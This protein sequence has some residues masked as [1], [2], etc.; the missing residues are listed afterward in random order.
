MRICRICVLPE[1][2]PGVTLDDTGV[3]NYCRQ[4]EARRPRLE[5]QRTTMQQRFEDLVREHRGHQTYDCLAAW[6]GGKD[7]TY[8]LWLLRER[9]HLNVLAYTFDNGFV[10]PTA[11]QNMERVSDRLG[12]DHVIFRPRFDLL[13]RIFSEVAEQ[14]D[15]YAE[16]A[17]SRASAVCNAC[18]GLAKGI[19]LQLAL[20]RDIPM[21]VF[22][23]SP[24]QVPLTSALFHRTPEML[25][26]MI[27]TLVDPLQQVV[28]EAAWAYFPSEELLS[29]AGQIPYDVA[30]LAFLDYDEGQIFQTINT[31]GWQL[32]S[33]TDPNSTNCLLN[34]FGNTT[35]LAKKSYHPYAMELA[36]LVRQGHMSREEALARLETPSHPDCVQCVKA[37]LHID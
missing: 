22:G 8:T 30:P 24:G 9:Y 23:W 29:R 11:F 26:A 19:A 18:M 21:M 6:S 27:R 3:C 5:K 33:D 17:L 34:A 28:A 1:S 12:V 4:Y 15:V 36:G 20:E 7:S 31:F 13:R 14:P 37:K 32:P 2:F 16:V 25:A 35:H 10:S